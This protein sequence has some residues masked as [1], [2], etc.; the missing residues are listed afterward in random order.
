MQLTKNNNFQKFKKIAVQQS[1]RNVKINIVQEIACKK[2]FS[3][4]TYG[5][6]M[7]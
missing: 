3:F 6:L 4:F 2:T 1:K 7:Q 5:P